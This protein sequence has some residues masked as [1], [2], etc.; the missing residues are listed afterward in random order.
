MRSGIVAVTDKTTSISGDSHTY[1]S[2][3]VYWWPDPSNPNGPYVA[4]DGQFNPEYKR[5]DYPRLLAMVANVRECSKA[6]Y[7]THDITYYDFL[8]RQLDTWF[9]HKDTRMYPHFDYSQFIP[10]RNAN[11]GNPQ[12]MIDAYNLND[13]LE[14]IRLAH[15]VKRLGRKRMRALRSWFR[16]FAQ[17]MQ[18]SS[19]GQTAAAYTNNQGTAYDVTLYNILLFAKKKSA[20]RAILS[21][22]YEKRL[23]QQVDAEG[24]QPEE[25]KRTRAYFY[26][27][28]NLTHLVD[29]CVMVS[30]DGQALPEP[31]RAKV[32]QSQN[33]LSRF[34]DQP[35]TFPYRESGDWDELKSQLKREQRRLGKM[36]MRGQ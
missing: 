36:P 11:R 8:C 27:L 31:I 33:Y 34:V 4:R 14:G 16:D 24:K 13:V 2:L 15:S 28:Y 35:S 26:S 29:F 9:I 20:R 32:H 22:F 30:R 23:L 25:L 10:G 17:W 18:E 5:Y 19:Y 3:S 12:G 21:S 6:Y 7:I 1:E